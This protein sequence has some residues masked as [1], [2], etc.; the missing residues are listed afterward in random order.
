MSSTETIFSSE[1][2]LEADPYVED[3][4]AE[5][6]T[7]NIVLPYVHTA[8]EGVERLGALIEEYGSAASV[9]AS[10]LSMPRRPGIWRMPADTDGWRAGCRRTSIS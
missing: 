7:Y 6:C 8:R 9:S 4:L 3:G 5:N 10:V 2:A 1:K